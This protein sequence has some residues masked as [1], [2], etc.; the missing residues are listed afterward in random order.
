MR[1]YCPD[2]EVRRHQFARRNSQKAERCAAK[3][4]QIADTQRDAETFHKYTQS[5]HNARQCLPAKRWGI[6]SGF[7]YSRRRHRRRHFY[8]QGG[9]ATSKYVNV[10]ITRTW[11]TPIR[12][13]PSWTLQVLSHCLSAFRPACNKL[14]QHHC[15]YDLRKYN[16]TNRVIPIW[17]SLTNH[18]VSAETV[19]TFKRLDKFWI[20][21]DVMY[22]YKAD[23]HGI[24]NRSII[25]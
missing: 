23:L 24:G 17:N 21:Q 7:V 22:N 15:H 5:A 18:V 12:H 10:Q 13:S 8:S 3:W 25:V 11:P 2:P 16:F 14:T 9:S 4:Q 19:N 20:D 1:Q 6:Y